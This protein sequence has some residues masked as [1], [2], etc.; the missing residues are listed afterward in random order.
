[1]TIS[2]EI[3]LDMDGVCVDFI[4]A[5][6]T[7]QGYD[8]DQMLKGWRNDYPGSLYPEPLMDKTATEFFT[9]SQFAGVHVLVRP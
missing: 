5:A 4:G 7:S 9:H 3:Y 1:M 6:L 2:P 8:A